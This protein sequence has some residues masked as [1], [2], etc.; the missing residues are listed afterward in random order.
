MA[1]L[2][3]TE[4]AFEGQVFPIDPGLT[5]GREAHNDIAMPGNRHASRDHA[6]VW[7]DGPQSWSLADLGSTNG[8]L[9][10]GSKV[11]REHLADGDEIRIGDFVFRFELSSADKPKPAQKKDAPPDLAAVLRGEAVAK[12]PVGQ[13]KAGETADSIEIQQRVLHYQKKSARGS[14]M[15][16]DIGQMAGAG[17]WLRILAAIAVLAGVAWV[18]M[19]FTQKARTPTEGFPEV[20]I[21]ETE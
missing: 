19:S 5:L 3:G 2:V 12:A 21:E 7:K 14:A 8:T 16:H 10:N 11:T 6:K 17:K 13:A 1:R 20:D 18:V 9:V 4:G 15:S